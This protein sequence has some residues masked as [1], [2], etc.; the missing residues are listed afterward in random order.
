MGLTAFLNI[1]IVLANIFIGEK[2][3]PQL[4]IM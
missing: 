4:N 2:V 1:G 3:L